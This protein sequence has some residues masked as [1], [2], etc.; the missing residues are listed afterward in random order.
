MKD[1]GV[2]FKL[3]AL[4]L[5]GLMV[6]ASQVFGAARIINGTEVTES[7]QDDSYPWI[8]S[9]M[10]NGSASCGASLIADQWVLTA[11]HCVTNMETGSVMSASNF[12]V[13]VND[14]HLEER[15]DEESRTVTEVYVAAGFDTTTLD[16]DIA[17]LKLSSTVTST[18][19]TLMSS[20]DFNALAFGESLKVM[21]WGNTVITGDDVKFNDVVSIYPNILRE[22]DID[23]ADFDECNANYG[24]LT[25]NVFCAGGNGITDSCQGDSGGPIMQLVDGEFQQV[26]IVSTGGTED[27]SCAALNYPGIYTRLSNY[28]SWI[29]SVMA[30]NET[31]GT[32]TDTGSEED[33][34]SSSS[35]SSGSLG[36]LFI[37]ALMSLLWGA[38]KNTTRH[39]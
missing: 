24:G 15:G 34:S 20:S 27:Q 22:V 37:F 28:H 5:A 14:Y 11:A 2:K 36:G 23:Y 6:L 35:S 17:V 9:L 4:I 16:S 3:S 39:A 38:R 30:G 33:T 10:I 8:T 19:V 32:R 13:V 25:N 29:S 7:T 18:P 12:T 21:G 26:G 1:A 31:P